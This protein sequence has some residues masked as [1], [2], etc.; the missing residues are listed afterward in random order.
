VL[1]LGLTPAEL[2]DVVVCCWFACPG[3]FPCGLPASATLQSS[4]LRSAAPNRNTAC[5][6]L[7]FMSL[8]LPRIF[9]CSRVT[10]IG[11]DRLR[12]PDLKRGLGRV[13]SKALTAVRGP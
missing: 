9:G 1:L 10:A 4:P 13:V 3:G 11:R 7:A 12:K 8:R 5:R 2:S 6:L